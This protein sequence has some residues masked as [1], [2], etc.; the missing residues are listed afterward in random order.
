LTDFQKIVK[1]SNFMK[2]RP[3]G[4]GGR[5]SCSML[6]DAQ[7]DMTEL[8]VVFRNFSKAPKMDKKWRELN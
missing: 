2:I 3:V 5:A 1:T 8:I 4:G 7:K 6:M